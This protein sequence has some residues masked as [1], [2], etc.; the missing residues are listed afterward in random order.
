M[1]RT[2]QQIENRTYRNSAFWPYIQVQSSTSRW[3]ITHKRVSWLVR[4]SINLTIEGKCIYTVIF[5][6]FFFPPLLCNTASHSLE[7]EV[8]LTL[9]E[10]SHRVNDTLR[11]N[12]QKRGNPIFPSDEK[13]ASQELDPTQNICLLIASESQNETSRERRASDLTIEGYLARENAIN[14]PH[15]RG[16]SQQ[17]QL[18]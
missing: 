8:N 16:I 18:V 14:Q 7:H 5:S 3:G 12:S 4:I 11:K 2:I 17:P 10:L 15:T 6:F 13:R 9:E 1:I